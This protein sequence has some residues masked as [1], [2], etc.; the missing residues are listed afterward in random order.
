MICGAAGQALQIQCI[1]GCHRI[2]PE[3][4]GS[5]QVMGLGWFPGS[6]SNQPDCCK[7]QYSKISRYQIAS[8]EGCSMPDTRFNDSKDLKIT[9]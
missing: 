9:F 1:L 4:R 5:G 2:Q 8:F 6:Y 7:N 3:S